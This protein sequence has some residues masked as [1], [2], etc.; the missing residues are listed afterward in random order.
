MLRDQ[1]HVKMKL[2]AENVT[3]FNA[4]DNMHLPDADAILLV[5]PS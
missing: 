1:H 4:L 2:W 3:R 5:L